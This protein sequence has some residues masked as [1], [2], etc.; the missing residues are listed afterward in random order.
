MLTQRISYCP[1]TGAANLVA[2]KP[3][4]IVNSIVQGRDQIERDWWPNE[5]VA[6]NHKPEEGLEEF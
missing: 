1:L 4:V 3:N 2:H 5:T 6:H